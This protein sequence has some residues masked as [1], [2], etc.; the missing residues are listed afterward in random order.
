MAGRHLRLMRPSPAGA[1]RWC[2]RVALVVASL[3]GAEPLAAAPD[4]PAPAEPLPRLCTEAGTV[5]VSGVSSGGFLAH[6]LHV[7]HSATIAGAG[8]FAAG[9]YA[10]AGSGYPASMLRALT[11]CSD[12]PD[13]LPFMGPPRVERSI[14][15]ARTAADAGSIDALSGLAGDRVF[16]FS[17]LKDTLVPSSVV[18]SVGDFYHAFGAGN[19]AFVNTI[20]AAHAMVTPDFGNPC[21]T[22]KSPFLNA[23]AFD[24]AGATLQ[25]LVGPL[26]PPSEP[27][28]RLVAFDQRSFADPRRSTGLADTGYL[29]VP[30]D[31]ESG[32]GCRLH[33]ALH[34]CAQTA[35]LIGDAFYRHAGYN[36]WAESNRI[37]ILYPQA[38]A[39]TRRFLGFEI[40]WPN[41]QGCWDWWGFTG[42][43][44]ATRTGPQIAAIQAMITQL[45]APPV[46]G[47]SPP[48]SSC[49]RAGGG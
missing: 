6:Q 29:Y 36:R 18:A 31:C 24:L 1:G 37:V 21:D 16:L 28:G 42:A 34:G 5:T 19:V 22:T 13:L 10:C 35:S 3:C 7:A 15:A 39:I 38:A 23:C 30:R 4:T 8:I 49:A 44:Y 11:V 40:P 17:G 33:V 47:S 14:E 41:P 20:A 26:A 25:G 46:N 45:A 9:P 12:I 43:D 32:A 2:R 48:G 27:Q